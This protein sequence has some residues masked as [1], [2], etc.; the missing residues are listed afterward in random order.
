MIVK[1]T[2]DT[3]AKNLEEMRQEYGSLNINIGNAS[4]ANVPLCNITSETKALR[5]LIDAGEVKAISYFPKDS[6]IPSTI[7]VLNTDKESLIITALEVARK[8]NT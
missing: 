1:N 7:L 4:V 8:L 3:L 6:A 2:A 5:K